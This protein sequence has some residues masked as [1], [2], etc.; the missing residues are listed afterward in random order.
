M[1]VGEFIEARGNSLLPK[2]G[3]FLHIV[4]GRNKDK[5]APKRSWTGAN[6]LVTE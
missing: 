5:V 1:N 2:R 4:E 6:M 3:H